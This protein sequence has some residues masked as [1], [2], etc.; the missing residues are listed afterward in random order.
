VKKRLFYALFAVLALVFWGDLRWSDRTDSEALFMPGLREEG[1]LKA[2]FVPDFGV[3]RIQE[4][5]P[6]GFDF[7]LLKWFADEANLH[8]DISFAPTRLAALDSVRSGKA[9]VACGNLVAQDAVGMRFGK[10]LWSGPLYWMSTEREAL[11][12]ED[13]L[14]VLGNSPTNE[15]LSAW[16][17][18]NPDLPLTV[19]S[20]SANLFTSFL[21]QKRSQPGQI[22]VAPKWMALA[23]KSKNRK[24]YVGAFPGTQVE[25]GWAFRAESVALETQ[26]SDWLVRKKSSRRY[27]HWFQTHYARGSFGPGSH[28]ISSIDSWAQKWARP[29]PPYDAALVLAVA[30]RESRFHRTAVSPAGAL[31]LMQLMP[32]TGKKFLPPGGDLHQPESNLRAGIQYMAFLDD[33]WKKKGVPLPDRLHFV[34]ASYNTGP[35]PVVRAHRS[36]KNKGLDPKK[37]HGHV[38]SVLRSPGRRYAREI[39]ELALCYRAYMQVLTFI[40]NEETVKTGSR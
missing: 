15:V 6:T 37:W 32:R 39:S 23:W 5:L 29:V 3:F 13:T 22:G 9:D 18:E 4:G 14:I 25:I 19:R 24:G 1:R 34:L 21:R 36:A 38:E 20:A 40:P 28:R 27:R 16:M 11:S 17:L 7:H 33:F 12:P 31:G 35:A 2:V 8:L 26:L 10:P 30:Y